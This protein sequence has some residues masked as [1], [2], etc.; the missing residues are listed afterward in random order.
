VT[1]SD[2]EKKA[3]VYNEMAQIVRNRFQSQ[4]LTVRAAAQVRSRQ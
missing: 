4:N 1:I 2:P 3:P